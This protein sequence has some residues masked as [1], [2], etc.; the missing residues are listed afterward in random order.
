MK[1]KTLYIVL[2][3]TA[4][5]LLLALLIG[6]SNGLNGLLGSIGRDIV[7]D[8]DSPI[9]NV[10]PDGS[11]T[12]AE[13]EPE[14]ESESDSDNVSEP[15]VVELGIEDFFVF[16]DYISSCSSGD[17]YVSCCVGTSELKPSTKYKVDINI[18]YAMVDKESFSSYYADGEYYYQYCPYFSVEEEPEFIRECYNQSMYDILDSSFVIETSAEELNDNYGFVIC[19]G[20]ACSI[21]DD[22]WVDRLIE[23]TLGYNQYLGYVEG[24][25]IFDYFERRG[26]SVT[27]T[28]VIE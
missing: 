18:P 7:T 22:A 27:F 2:S 19:L 16:Y 28:E 1:K 13:S 4:L 6:A 21:S 5:L 12:D 11:A 10:D 15:R 3:A 23:G 14:S 9:T 24:Y 26:F 25:D 20:K 8:S 17:D